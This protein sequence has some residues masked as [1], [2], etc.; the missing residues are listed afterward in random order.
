MAFPFSIEGTVAIKTTDLMSTISAVES[1]IRKAKPTDMIRDGAKIRFRAGLFRLVTN[2]N[3]LVPIGSGQLLF[4]QEADRVLIHYS[5]SLVQLFVTSTLLVA[6]MLGIV[7][8]FES[9]YPWACLGVMPLA[10]LWLFG[11]NY[12]TTKFRFPRFLR[13][14]SQPV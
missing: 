6:I 14:G 2:W 1:A 3:L 11:A 4:S 8:I 7:P 10:W 12:L 5:L 13:T 9:E